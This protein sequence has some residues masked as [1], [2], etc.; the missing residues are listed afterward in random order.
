MRCKNF[1]RRSA[2]CSGCSIGRERRDR[3]RSGSTTQIREEPGVTGEGQ[4]QAVFKAGYALRRDRRGGRAGH[5]RR[6]AAPAS[7]P[8]RTSS[9]PGMYRN[10]HR[11]RKRSRSA[12]SSGREP[13][14]AQNLFYSGYPITP[15]SSILHSSR[16]ATR[17]SATMTFQAEDEIAAMASPRSAP[18]TA[19]QIGGDR[20]VS[21]PG[22]ALKGEAIGLAHHDR[23]AAS[24]SSTSQRGGPVDRPADQDRAVGPLSGGLWPQTATRRCR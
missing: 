19:D 10:G 18:R 1:C 11:Q 20:I 24:S 6:E 22:I 7:G 23:A 21:G 13:R 12:W 17:T 3:D 2:W 9:R 5:R 16:E 4:R 8:R 14:R 15:A